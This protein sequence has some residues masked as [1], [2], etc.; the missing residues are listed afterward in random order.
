MSSLLAGN[1]MHAD[2]AA[3]AH[4]LADDGAMQ[5]LEPPRAGRFADDHLRDV[6]RLRKGDHV[7]G[8]A[9][10][11][12]RDGDGLSAEGLGQ[13]KGIGD[14]VA[15]LLAQL[16]AALGLD[17]E[18]RPRGVQA[19]GQTLGIAHQPGCPRVLAHANEETLSAAQGPGMARACISFSSCSST[20]SAVR[21]KAS[22]RSAVRLAGE[23]KCSSARSACLGT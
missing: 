1:D 19:V 21:R 8:D 18:R 2:I 16:Q 13:P 23:K 12:A 17:I 15:L 22:S 4:E 3:A 11:A 20:R 5:Q 9:A 14:A 7:V 10:I 6:V